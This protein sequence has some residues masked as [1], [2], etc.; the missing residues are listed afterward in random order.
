MAK[1][2]KVTVIALAPIALLSGRVE[3]GALSEVTESEAERL[4]AA[5]LASLAQGGETEA[6]SGKTEVTEWK[7]KLSPQEYLE[8]YPE[9]P[10]AELARKILAAAEPAPSE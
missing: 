10:Q 3:R 7:K 2:A 6:E 5:G 4:I 8:K 1:Q 9:G